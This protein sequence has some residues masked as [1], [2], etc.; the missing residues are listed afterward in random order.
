MQRYDPDTLFEEVAF[1]A[2][3]FGWSHDE[4]LELPHWERQRWC[5]E[6]SDI[7][8]RMNETVAPD[9]QPDRGGGGSLLDD[10]GDGIV[11]QNSLEDL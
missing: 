6:I 8:E 11:L 4:V 2:Y 10:D 7:N 3:H 9:H 1:V 5:E